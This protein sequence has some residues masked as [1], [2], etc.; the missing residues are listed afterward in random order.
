MT[1]ISSTQ[2]ETHAVQT[3]AT[4]QRRQLVQTTI[5]GETHNPLPQHHK[6]RCIPQNTE[7]QNVF[8]L[9]RL[10]QSILHGK[11]MAAKD[12]EYFGDTYPPN[13]G[14]NSTII[15]FQNIGPQCFSLYHQTSAAT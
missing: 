6:R 15:T 13:Q 7:S 9:K 11:N 2:A 14:K 5:T 12:S 8:Q 3:Q 4:Y 10:T 1:T